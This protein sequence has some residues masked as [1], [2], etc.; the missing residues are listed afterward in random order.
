MTAWTGFHARLWAGVMEVVRMQ[1]DRSRWRLDMGTLLVARNL[2]LA[3]GA[4]FA[5]LQASHAALEEECR[6]L[7]AALQRAEAGSDDHTEQRTG[8]G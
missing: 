1:E 6:T 8:R 2:L 3:L 7:R 5:R 4:E